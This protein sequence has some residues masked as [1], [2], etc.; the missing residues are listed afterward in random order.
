MVTILGSLPKSNSTLVTDLEARSDNI[1][2]NYV[3]QVLVHEEQKVNG[4]ISQVIL[5]H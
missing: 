5:I 1:S 2:L 4:Q 3:Q